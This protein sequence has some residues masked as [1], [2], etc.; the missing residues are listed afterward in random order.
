MLYPPLA[1]KMAKVS[2]ELSTTFQTFDEKTYE[3]TNNIESAC[4]F[5]LCLG[6]H[7]WQTRV[8]TLE[9]EEAILKT[10]NNCIHS[11]SKRPYAQVTQIT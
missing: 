4:I 5:V 2:G 7:G 3:V 9:A 11:I 6:T 8:L 10:D 1:G